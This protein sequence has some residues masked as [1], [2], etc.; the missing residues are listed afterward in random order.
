MTTLH[1]NLTSSHPDAAEP[2]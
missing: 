1:V 2:L